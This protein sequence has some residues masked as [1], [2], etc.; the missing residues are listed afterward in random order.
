ML[1]RPLPPFRARPL[2]R[3]TVRRSPLMTFELIDLLDEM[4]EF[5]VKARRR[6]VRAKPVLVGVEKKPGEAAGG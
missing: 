2:H 1:N 5:A 4:P 6:P 3:V